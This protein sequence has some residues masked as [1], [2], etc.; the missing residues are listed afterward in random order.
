MNMSAK[1]HGTAVRWDRRPVNE[2]KSLTETVANAAWNYVCI[3]LLVVSAVLILPASI[4][5]SFLENAQIVRLLFLLFVLSLVFDLILV[6][7]SH[8]FAEKKLPAFFMRL[9]FV[10]VIALFF[11]RYFINYYEKSKD[12]IIKGWRFFASEYYE[13]YNRIMGKNL[14]FGEGGDKHF[15]TDMSYFWLLVIVAVLFLLSVLIGKK[16]IFLLMPTAAFYMVMIIGRTPE[17]PA[18]LVFVLGAFM[19]LAGPIK[20]ENLLIRLGA[21]GVFMLVFVIAGSV[22]ES[23]AEKLM[24]RAEATKDFQDAMEARIGNFFSKLFLEKDNDISNKKPK[25]KN[26][27]VMVIT[28]DKKPAE[29]LYFPNYYGTYYKDGV[30]S[31]RDSDFE[32]ACRENGIGTET[33]GKYLF[34]SLYQVL[35][36]DVGTS[37]L[38]IDY[39]GLAG[40]AM[41]LPYGSL[42]SEAKVGYS[43]DVVTLKGLI[44]GS[45]KVT[46]LTNHVFYYNRFYRMIM[47]YKPEGN[48]GKFYS[49]YNE[50][51]FD[52]DLQLSDN[53]QSNRYLFADGS[54]YEDGEYKYEYKGY[55][56]YAD[57]WSQIESYRKTR[58]NDGNV[59]N[60]TEVSYL[61]TNL[62]RLARARDVSNYLTENYSYSWN[63]DSIKDGTDPIEYFLSTSKKGYCEHFA[64]AGVMLLRGAGVPARYASG[65]VLKPYAFKKKGKSYVASIID[66]NAHAW[67]EIYLENIG[68]VPV[69]VTPGYASTINNMPT[70]E[71]EAERRNERENSTPTPTPTKAATK[72]PTPTPT[73]TDSTITPTKKPTKAA[74]TKTPKPTK[75]VTPTPA[76]G[77]KGSGS[78]GDGGDDGGGKAFPVKIIIIA[79]SVLFGIFVLILAFRKHMAAVRKKL[80]DDLRK[81]RYRNA[82]N[83]MN[84]RLYRRLRRKGKFIG[85]AISGDKN[86]PGGITDEKYKTVLKDCYKDIP[87]EEWDRYMET[88]IKAAFSENEITKEEAAL[89]YRLYKK[90]R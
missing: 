2:R 29:N 41:Y 69:E 84:R 72:T 62:Y 31:N 48:L 38:D 76:G 6:P 26:V 71:D 22:F 56:S 52:H 27:E 14:F 81:K 24:G 70:D 61:S 10:L 64:S 11:Y 37:E 46:S 78:G 13:I 53:I 34:D 44:S 88:V 57:E 45:T 35:E 39:K 77:K 54:A 3:C 30:W 40:R 15:L 16:H 4:E 59:V 55:S 32:E 18:F 33:A 21:L 58:D 9:S 90:C 89:V 74:V 25:Y 8:A 87:G 85:L 68:W 49:W 63:L 5:R 65:Y 50:Y 79:A 28:S 43:G 67:V 82:I 83:S 19:L 7:I 73:E 1:S 36:E 66:R 20:K 80:E 86:S 60:V 17:W 75:T 51:A 42:S 23:S 12:A 47:E